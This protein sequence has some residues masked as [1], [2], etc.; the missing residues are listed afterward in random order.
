MKKILKLNGNEYASHF[1]F[2]IIEICEKVSAPKKVSYET[3]AIYNIK[4]RC[5]TL[6]LEELYQISKWGKDEEAFDRL[7]AIKVDIRNIK[8]YYDSV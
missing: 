3:P 8:K 2:S 7:N 5:I 4:V 6:D 1:Q